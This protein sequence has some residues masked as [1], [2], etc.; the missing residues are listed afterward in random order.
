MTNWSGTWWQRPK[1]LQSKMIRFKR[2]AYSEMAAFM[3]IA[4][5]DHGVTFNGKKGNRQFT[6]FDH[7]LMVK[8]QI[9][10]QLTCD[11]KLMIAKEIIDSLLKEWTDRGRDEIKI[12][13]ND[14]FA[15]DQQGKVNIR[16]ILTLRRHAIKDPKWLEA[17]DLISE[18][19]QVSGSKSYFR[20]YER[21]GPEGKYINI[22]LDFAAL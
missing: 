16:K 7:N 21:T 5:N 8:V 2:R 3:E 22:P 20:V 14:A 1:K 9:S 11:E 4:A 6:S 12:L 17:M 19:L 18:S 13:V 15:V 10:D